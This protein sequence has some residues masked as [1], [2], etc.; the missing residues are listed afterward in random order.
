MP[1]V[2][3]TGQVVAL[4]SSFTWETGSQ[5]YVIGVQHLQ[6]TCQCCVAFALHHA[7]AVA[8]LI[9]S[10]H[11]IATY[12][13][14]PVGVTAAGRGPA[15]TAAALR[16]PRVLRP[17]RQVWTPWLLVHCAIPPLILLPLVR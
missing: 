7:E 10:V 2:S 13:E 17:G 8:D 4:D 1:F 5:T 11:A 6:V 15:A 16:P 9:P 3:S 12:I 14:T